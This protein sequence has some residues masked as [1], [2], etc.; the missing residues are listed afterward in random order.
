MCE[1]VMCWCRQFVPCP[2]VAECYY[3]LDADIAKDSSTE[4]SIVAKALDDANAVLQQ[5]NTAMPGH[6]ALE[7]GEW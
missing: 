2:K 7:V 1:G 3:I 5:R 4:A 6:L